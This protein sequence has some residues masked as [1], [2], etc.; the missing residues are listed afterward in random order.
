MQ[1]GVRKRQ[2]SKLHCHTEDLCHSPCCL[3]ADSTASRQF[4]RVTKPLFILDEIQDT[5]LWE[6]RGAGGGGLE[7]IARDPF[8]VTPERFM[9]TDTDSIFPLQL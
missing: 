5:C 6:G 3:H 1:T 8:G 9:V 4:L 7:G 2:L